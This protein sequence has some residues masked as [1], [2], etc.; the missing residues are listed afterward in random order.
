MKTLMITTIALLCNVALAQD[1]TFSRK[2][3]ID[4]SVEATV[5]SACANN[6]LSCL[7]ISADSCAADV[8]RLLKNDC[9]GNVP[10][11]VSDMEKVPT[12]AGKLAGCAVQALLKKHQASMQKN[13]NS[14]ACQSLR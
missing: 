14:P 8:T 11:T 9:A 3:I 7:K 12:Y 6:I 5:A 4:M 2:D 10:E 13:F 1:V